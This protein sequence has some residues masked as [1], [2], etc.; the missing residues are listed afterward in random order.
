M[1]TPRMLPP[2]AGA[3]SAWHATCSQP[4]GAQPSTSTRPPA[5]QRLSHRH[6]EPR[7]CPRLFYFCAGAPE[8][9]SHTGSPGVALGCTPLTAVVP[10]RAP[11]CVRLCRRAVGEGAA[12][13]SRPCVLP[14]TFRHDLEALLR[15][16][17]RQAEPRGGAA[18]WHSLM[19]HGAERRPASGPGACLYLQQLIRRA[20]EVALSLRGQ[21]SR[22]CPHRL[23]QV[24]RR[25]ARPAAA[26]TFAR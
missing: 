19:P 26:P 14:R 4:P 18:A 2:R 17:C 6:K 11:W 8:H 15:A 1:S 3:P 10:S 12:G 16:R 7:L 9:G 22:C 13:Q 25:A 24:A 5:A 23:R 20:G 21:R